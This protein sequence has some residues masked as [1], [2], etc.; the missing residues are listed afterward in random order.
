MTGSTSD[1]PFV[2]ESQEQKNENNN[3]CKDA[4]NEMAIYT[5]VKR[6]AH[7]ST[8]EGQQHKKVPV[9]VKNR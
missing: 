9:T 4:G 6:Q 8:K 2:H 1:V 3:L 7:R 5:V